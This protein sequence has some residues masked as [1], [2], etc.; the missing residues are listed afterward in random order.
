MLQFFEK[1]KVIVCDSSSV[2]SH[3]IEVAQMW[4]FAE[5]GL[6]IRVHI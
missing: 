3:E 2:A 1:S 4:Y 6:Q 5:T